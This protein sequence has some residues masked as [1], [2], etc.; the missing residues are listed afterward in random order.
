GRDAALRERDGGGAARTLVTLEVE[1]GGADANGYEPLR[2]HGRLFGFL[3]S[4]RYAHSLGKSLAMALVER[5]FSAP[6]TALSTH[7][8][9]EERK[10]RVLAASPWDPKGERMRK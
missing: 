7:I 1:D 8:T 2:Q 3:N 9:G 4:G 5:E 10:A 6:D